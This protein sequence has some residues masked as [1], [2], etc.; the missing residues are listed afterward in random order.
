MKTKSLLLSSCIIAL[1][2]F[3]SEAQTNMTNMIVN[4]SF[5]DNVDDLATDSLI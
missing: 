1:S 4:P 2:A 5:E 3:V